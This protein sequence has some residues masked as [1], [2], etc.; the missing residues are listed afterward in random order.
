M[1][2]CIMHVHSFI[3]IKTIV[4][5]TFSLTRRRGYLSSPLID[6]LGGHLLIVGVC[7]PESNNI[8]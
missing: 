8:K 2:K 6:N 5:L 4:F 7:L 3:L 1:R